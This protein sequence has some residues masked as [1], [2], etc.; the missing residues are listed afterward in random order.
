MS[1]RSEFRVV[2]PSLGSPRRLTA[3]EIHF[4]RSITK[5]GEG[6]N[7]I[8]HQLE[9]LLVQD[10]NDGGMGSL[11]FPSRR[12]R[13]ERRLGRPLVQVNFID[14]DG[15]PVSALINLDQEEELF[16]LDVWKV[17]FSPLCDFPDH[18]YIVTTSKPK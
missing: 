12:K 2:D 13:Q 3:Q 7:A 8:L 15:I 17:D 10:M 5:D 9:E 16:E 4:L 18:T 14:H 1:D 6:G 11:Y